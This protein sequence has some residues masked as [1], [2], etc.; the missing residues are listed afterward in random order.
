MVCWQFVMIFFLGSSFHR[1]PLLPLLILGETDQDISIRLCVCLHNLYVVRSSI[2]YWLYKWRNRKDKINTK[3]FRYIRM[4][5]AFTR[6][7]TYITLLKCECN[8]KFAWIFFFYLDFRGCVVFYK[9]KFER[10]KSELPL[11]GNIYS[12][13]RE[14]ISLNCLFLWE[15]PE[16]FSVRSISIEK[17]LV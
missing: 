17:I 16:H 1:L 3:N 9:R 4:R 14:T 6:D 10:T 2:L 15:T 11:C 12:V 8:W 7:P 5:V 13:Y